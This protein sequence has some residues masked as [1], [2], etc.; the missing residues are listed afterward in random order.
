MEPLACSQSPLS[1]NDYVK[2]LMELVQNIHDQ[3]V[4]KTGYPSGPM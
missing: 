2:E 1:Y 4:S 3:N